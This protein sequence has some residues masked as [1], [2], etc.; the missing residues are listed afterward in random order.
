INRPAK[1]IRRVSGH[2]SDWIEAIKG[3]PASSANFEYSSRLTEIAL[4]GVLSVRMGGAEIRWDPK[5]MKAK[6]LPEADQYIK[7]SYRKGWEVV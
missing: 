2:H 5:N 6:G 7:E 3:G 1:S 4:L